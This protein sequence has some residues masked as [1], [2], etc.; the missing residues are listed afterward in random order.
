MHKFII[1]NI[2]EIEVDPS[3]PVL[4]KIHFGSKYYLHKGKTLRESADKLLYDVFRGMISPKA[5]TEAYRYII[6]YCKQK[7][8]L[9][10]VSIEIL[11][12]SDPKKILAAED[13]F[14]IK[15]K[16][17]ADS[18]NNL[19]VPP[20]KPEWMIKHTLQARCQA[21]ILSGIVNDKKTKFKFCPNCG[22]LNK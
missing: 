8:S 6:E 22:R 12:N 19:S 14:Y 21:C 10:K 1:S 20:Y 7:T 11:L 16:G 17:D 9:H 13:K 2:D 4:Y 5:P 18:L 15:M 3:K